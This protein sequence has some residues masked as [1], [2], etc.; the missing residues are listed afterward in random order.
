M[1][2]KIH[3]ITFDSNGKPRHQ[4]YQTADRNWSEKLKK[5]ALTGE[6]FVNEPYKKSMGEN[7]SVQIYSQSMN[8]TVTVI[9][10]ISEVKKVNHD[11][12]RENEL[13]KSTFFSLREGVIS[14][15]LNNCV[16]MM[17]ALAEKMTG[18]NRDEAVGMPF[19]SVFVLAGEGVDGG[20]NDN[21]EVKFLVHKSKQLL[22]IEECTAPIEDDEGNIYGKVVVFRDVT[23]KN[24]RLKHIEYL[25][26][27]D[28]LTGLY[29]RRFFDEELKRID[30]ERNLPISLVMIDV[31]GLKLTNDAFGHQMGDLVLKK[32]ATILKLEF[33]ADDIVARIGG[34]EFAVLLPK[35]SKDVLMPILE[36]IKYA[37]EHTKIEN[38]LLSFSAGSE[39]KRRHTENIMDVFIRAENEMYRNK[40]I[41]S[42]TMRNRTIQMLLKSLSEKY[43]KNN[44]QHAQVKHWCALIGHGL[45]LNQDELKELENVALIYDIGKISIS[46]DL[47]SKPDILTETEYEIIKK[48]PEVGYQ[49]LKSV[50]QY[51]N[52]AEYALSYHERWNGSGYPRKLVGEE[53]PRFARIIAIADTYEAL[54]SERPYRHAMQ[55]CNALKYIESKAAIEFDPNIVNVFVMQLAIEDNPYYQS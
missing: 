20:L 27:H 34:D 33:R 17:N 4:F 2:F 46:D 12:M 5:E 6:A 48:H 15:D 3:D 14:V 43:I 50:E 39:T 22:A 45:N 25:S 51:V 55:P 16:I 1:F 37:A 31:N 24:D 21:E 35:T 44:I 49:I 32:V 26:Y 29:N 52:I 19:D 11:L 36:R 54:I 9:T 30:T 7:I 38:I 18:L 23:E 53:I 41:E 42:K 13:L 40:L 8:Q 28:Q 10:D 47:L